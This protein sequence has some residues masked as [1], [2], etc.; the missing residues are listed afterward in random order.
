MGN[1][2]VVYAFVGP[3]SHTSPHQP[4]LVPSSITHPRL[5]LC[6]SA[7]GEP[8]F[9]AI[10]MWGPPPPNPRHP[11]INLLQSPPSEYVQG[12]HV[13]CLLN[14]MYFC[15]ISAQVGDLIDVHTY[16]GPSSPHPTA[17]RASVLGEFGGL[18]LH[19]TDHSWI[20]GEAFSYELQNSAAAL[21]V[22]PP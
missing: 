16:V 21:E 22:C 15:V 18:G 11:G 13:V 14:M 12:K 5:H 7:G 8:S 1:C 2:I 3:S 17:T 10:V 20:P 9:T 4:R 19:L 6:L